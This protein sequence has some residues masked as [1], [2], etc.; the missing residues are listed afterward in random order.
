M[1]ITIPMGAVSGELVMMDTP[2]G[3]FAVTIPDGAGE[4]EPML[5]PLPLPSSVAYTPRGS[6]A[7]SKEVE[8]ERQ[9]R[10]LMELGF[11]AQVTRTLT[12]SLSLTL[13]LTLTATLTLTLTSRAPSWS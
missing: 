4:G 11:H 12:L 1:C 2:H 9:L 5:V 8:R 10:T 6:A 7:I 3:R 13:T